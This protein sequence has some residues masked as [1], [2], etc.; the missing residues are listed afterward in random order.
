LKRPGENGSFANT[1]RGSTFRGARSL[2]FSA[3]SCSTKLSVHE[4][5]LTNL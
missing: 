1:S 4:L 5:S 2:S 3:V